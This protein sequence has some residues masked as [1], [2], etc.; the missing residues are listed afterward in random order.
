MHL[1]GLR[2]GLSSS[3]R[4]LTWHLPYG[5]ASYCH[6]RHDELWPEGTG[7]AFALWQCNLLPL[8]A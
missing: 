8:E 4:E 2:A 5:H 3:L 7:L 6:F 1:M